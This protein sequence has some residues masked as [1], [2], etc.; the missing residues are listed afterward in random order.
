MIPPVIS[1]DQGDALLDWVGLT[2][3]LAHGHTLPKAEIGDTFLYR[4]PDTLLSRAAWIDGL[5][6]AVKTATIFPG[7]VNKPSIN[8]GVSLYSDGDGTLEAIEAGATLM[9]LVP[10]AIQIMIQHP[11]AAE[12]DFSGLRY[13][14]YGAAPMPLELLKEAVKTMPDTGFMQVYGMTETTGTVSLLPPE[15]HDVGG[16]ERMRSA[17]KAVPG[18]K[19]E[20]RGSDNTE[21]PRGE[22]GEIC[23]HSP[24]NTAG[25]WQLPEATAKTIDPDGWLHTGDAGILDADG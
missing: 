9:F 24:S 3:A 18:V 13:L 10:A 21:V 16:N 1:F 19:I 11:K 14:M 6:M 15:D 5:G 25:Y 17:G 20:I 23:I 2:K 4:D 12:T 8:G 22:I 7:N